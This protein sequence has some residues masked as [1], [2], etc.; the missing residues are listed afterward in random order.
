MTKQRITEYIPTSE[1]L[2]Q[3]LRETAQ[4]LRLAYDRFNYVSEPELVESSIYAIDSLKAKYSYLL[5]R[6]KELNGAPVRRSVVIRSTK[7]DCVAASA[8]EGGPIC[9][10]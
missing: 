8:M 4:E 9:P 3:E 10:L 5:R 6:I 1:E 2:H 7:P